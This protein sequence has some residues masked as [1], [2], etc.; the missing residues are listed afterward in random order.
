MCLYSPHGLRLGDDFLFSLITMTPSHTHSLSFSYLLLSY[1][2]QASEGFQIISIERGRTKSLF[3]LKSQI[4]IYPRIVNYFESFQKVVNLKTT[5]IEL[6]CSPFHRPNPQGKTHNLPTAISAPP[7]RLRRLNPLFVSLSL[8]LPSHIYTPLALVCATDADNVNDV[9][10]AHDPNLVTAD[11]I[12]ST[13]CM[14][15]SV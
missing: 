14:Q 9:D 3:N 10:N 8:P 11:M 5:A 13:A 6:Q 7:H 2:S 15:R 12:K 1:S 4:T